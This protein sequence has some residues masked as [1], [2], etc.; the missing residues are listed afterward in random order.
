SSGRVASTLAS[1]SVEDL[2]AEETHGVELTML[3]YLPRHQ[4]TAYVGRISLHFVQETH[5]NSMSK[6]QVGMGAFVFLFFAN[7]QAQARAHIA[8]RS[9]MTLILL[10]IDQAQIIHNDRS[11]AY[12]AV[13]ISDNVV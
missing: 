12:V 6:G 10:S 13:S 4:M 7:V 8:T 3:S 2:A 5:I 9:E 11:Q 1:I